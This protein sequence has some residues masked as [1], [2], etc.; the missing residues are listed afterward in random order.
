M[1]STRLAVPR[2]GQQGSPTPRRR[3]TGRAPCRRAPAA[4]A[5][6]S[7]RRTGPRSSARAAVSDR[8]R[9][10][11]REPP[12]A[13]QASPTDIGKVLFVLVGSGSRQFTGHAL[14]ESFS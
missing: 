8:P 7:R 9:L 2:R 14:A 1:P 5:S 4:A 3:S 12:A 11:R 6:P 10:R 13:R